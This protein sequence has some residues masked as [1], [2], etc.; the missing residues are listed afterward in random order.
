MKTIRQLI[1]QSLTPFVV[2]TFH[3]IWYNSDD[4]WAK[5]RYLG[6][7]IMQ[8]P[9]DMQLYQELIYD[10]KPDYILQTG[11]AYGGS[12]LYF[13]HLLDNMKAPESSIV[14]G[15]DIFLT[16]EAK[17]LSHARIKLFEGSSTDPSMVE[18]IRQTLPQGK[19]FVIL[20]SDHAMQHVRKE[21]DIYKE[22]VSP[23]SYMVVEDTNVNGHPVNKSHGPGPLEAVRDFLKTDTRFISDDDLWLRNKFSFHHGG[24]LKRISHD[25]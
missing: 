5:N 14:V 10:L 18:K 3:K 1:T 13:A 2:K 21:L 9:F 16:P 19:G 8:C 20:D 6:Y 15:I 25:Q 12:L 23:G 7:R 17:T 11:I 24:W 4:T 22:F